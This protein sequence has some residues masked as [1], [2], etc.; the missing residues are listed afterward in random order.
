MNRR[1]A[2]LVALIGSPVLLARAQQ[3]T[4]VARIGFL[5]PFARAATVSSEEA[6]RQGLRELGW[7][8][9]RNIAIEY[10]YAE[11]KRERLPGLAADLVR[12]KVDVIVT[13]VGSDTEAALK[14]TRTIPI[15]SATGAGTPGVLALGGSL[16]RPG[17]NVT[18]STQLNVDLI[19]KRLELLRQIVPRLS[20][21]AVLWNPHSIGSTNNW[22]EMQLPARQLGVELQ[23]LEVRSSDDFETALN[24]AIKGRA[25]ALILTPDPLIDAHM[26]PIA[27]FAAKNRLPSTF[28]LTEFV[29][30][31]GLI[32]YGV[33]RPEQ[34][35][36]AAGFVDK[37]LKG[38]RPGE[39]PIERPSKFELVINLKTAKAIGIRIPQSVLLQA[40]KVIE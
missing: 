23:S 4:R 25:S 2:V 39:L 34:F 17:G 37:I 13:S 18:G 5:S 20:R 10:R 26:K 38:A 19:G 27:E 21:V 7:I 28:H 29:E 9:E 14:T 24:E 1:R 36:R 40:N 33:N 30:A 32:A 16:A 22:K 31:G 8:E 11:G 12:L 15:V 6:F 3:P 35:R